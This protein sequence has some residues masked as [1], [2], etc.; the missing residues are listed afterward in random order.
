[1]QIHLRSM[2]LSEVYV[3]PRG[4]GEPPFLIANFDTGTSFFLELDDAQRLRDELTRGLREA[5]HLAAAADAVV[6]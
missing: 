3:N 6:R 1:M 4:P 5:G 2:V